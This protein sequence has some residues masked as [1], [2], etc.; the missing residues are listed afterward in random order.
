MKSRS[1]QNSSLL[2]HSSSLFCFR[3]RSIYVS[4]NGNAADAVQTNK[5]YP[6]KSSPF[7]VI[8]VYVFVYQTNCIFSVQV[9]RLELLFVKV[10]L[11]VASES[12]TSD[13]KFV[14]KDI[15]LLVITNIHENL[16]FFIGTFLNS[17]NIPFSWIHY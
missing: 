17:Q 8:L 3:I 7:F 6:I 1:T 5:F 14:V 9:H 13:A 10:S 15:Q 4:R 12:A 2:K 16:Q 11:L